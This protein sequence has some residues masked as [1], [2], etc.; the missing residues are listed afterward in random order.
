M[1]VRIVIFNG[2]FCCCFICSA[3]PLTFIFYTVHAQMETGI[4]YSND[5]INFHE[6]SLLTDFFFYQRDDRDDLVFE[7][8]ADTGTLSPTTMSPKPT[9]SPTVKVRKMKAMS[10]VNRKSN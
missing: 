5:H 8:A 4:I 6:D 7:V 2:Y 3:S 10:L 1:C 9:L